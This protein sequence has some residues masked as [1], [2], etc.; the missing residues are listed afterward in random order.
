MGYQPEHFPDFGP[1][2]FRATVNDYEKLRY[3]LKSTAKVELSERWAI[4]LELHSRPRLH[5]DRTAGRHR[6]HRHFGRD[7]SA[8]AQQSQATSARG[9]MP[10]QPQAN[11]HGLDHVLRRL[12]N[13]F[14]SQR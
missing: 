6:D 13:L 10:Q 12:S 8:R 9:A 2:L 3:I 1:L 11:D 14:G 5:P 4:Y 7:A